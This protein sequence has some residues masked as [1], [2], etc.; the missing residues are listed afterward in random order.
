MGAFGKRY[1]LAAQ[2][3]LVCAA[4]FVSG[5]GVLGFGGGSSTGAVTRSGRPTGSVGATGGSPTD[6][7]MTGGGSS[8]M[9]VLPCDGGVIPGGASPAVILHHS[10][11]GKTLSVPLG[12]VVAIRLEG[13]FAWN[14]ASV[15]PADALTPVGAQGA[16]EDGECI[17]EYRVA[18][19]GDAI[20][21]IS[22]GALCK[23]GQACLQY[24]VAAWYTIRGT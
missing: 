11:S 15:M 18:K 12:A 1:W 16:L 4:L 17:W 23:P 6:G 8:A 2:S 14:R 22:G 24:A 20:V 13:K 9:E 7:D 3:L 21:T 10:D 19:T 5:C